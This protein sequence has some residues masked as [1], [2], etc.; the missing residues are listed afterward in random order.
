MLHD[1]RAMGLKG[2]GLEE[3]ACSIPVKNWM[4]G[5]K[6]DGTIKHV[7]VYLTFYILSFVASP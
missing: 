5:M 3:K 4:P 2:R 1:G 7:Y 6:V